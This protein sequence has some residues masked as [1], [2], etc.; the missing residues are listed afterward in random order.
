MRIYLSV[1]SGTSP[2]EEG[3]AGYIQ[4][5]Q[6]IL[7]FTNDRF[8]EHQGNKIFG[9]VSFPAPL[10]PYIKPAT[11][12]NPPKVTLRK[13]R[14]EASLLAKQVALNNKPKSCS[15]FISA[16]EYT[17]VRMINRESDPSDLVES[18]TWDIPAKVM[19]Y[20]HARDGLQINQLRISSQK[21]NWMDPARS[22]IG[23]KLT[24][25]ALAEYTRA[26]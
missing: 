4:G 18:M 25:V 26:Q 15:T 1:S 8:F 12:G 19:N 10:L 22:N 24:L 6:D 3:L 13:L 5:V 9:D 17:G 11:K 14:L 23:A 20:H 7:S 16:N 2:I 21:C